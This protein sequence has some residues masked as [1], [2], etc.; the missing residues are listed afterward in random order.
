MALLR[1]LCYGPM[2][3]IDEEYLN[4]AMVRSVRKL[5]RG[6]DFR[7]SHRSLKWKDYTPLES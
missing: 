7:F 1:Y 5:L 2:V 6:T 3:M 4:G